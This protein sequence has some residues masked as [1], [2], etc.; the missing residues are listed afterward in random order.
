MKTPVIGFYGESKTGKTTLL[1][2]I[3]RHLSKDGFNVASIKV[4]DKEIC[5]DSKNKDTWKHAD[6]G[7]KLVVF[8]SKNET[9]FLLKRKSGNDEIV[10]NIKRLGNFDIIIVEGANDDSIP[11]IRIGEI[12]ER[13]N[14]IFTYDGDFEG[15][16]SFI[17]NEIHGRN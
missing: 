12:K 7:S 10:D 5:I 8:S 16:I 11:K 9:D 4:S 17:K 2:E 3:I 15:L 13:K 14:T 6:A 1:V